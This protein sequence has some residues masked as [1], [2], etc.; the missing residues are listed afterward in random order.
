MAI[1]KIVS[2]Y[3]SSN[4]LFECDV[5]DTV[6]SGLAMRHALERA[7]DGGADLR[8]ANLRD[9]NLRGADLR[10]ANLRDA[11]LRG[12]DLRGA[13]LRD[14]NLSDANLRDANL[15]D[16]DLSGAD[17]RGADLRDA[18]LRDANLRDAN[19]RDADLRDADLSDADLSDA[20]LGFF[21]TDFFDVLIRAP[22][23]IAGLREA[24]VAGRVDGSTYEGA[25]ACFVGTISNVRGVS[26]ESLGNGI[27]P[28]SSRP[29]E[30]WFMS[31]RK[32]DT[33]ETNQVSRVTV[34][35]ID[36]FV[37]LLAMATVPATAA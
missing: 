31:I 25:C 27:K 32:G 37:G 1:Q 35:W 26:Y 29:A 13:D 20:D 4:V 21:K 36:E 22:R 33:P 2:R 30:R 19:L 18:N 7:V 34:E 6:A 15:S 14:A 3:S 9:A 10:G 23:E 8:D 28:N 11:D 5:P 24:L 16:A 17:L 12:A